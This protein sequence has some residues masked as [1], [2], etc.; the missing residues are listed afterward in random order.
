MPWHVEDIMEKRIEFVARSLQPGVNFS[1]VCR[2]FGI[3][4]TTGYLWKNRYREVGSFTE[5]HEKS[6]RPHHTP[7]RT[8]E[9]I[10][11]RVLHEQG[12]WGL[13]AKKLQPELAKLGIRLPWITIHRILQRHQKTDSSE[14][15]PA[16][17]HRF[18]REQP[19]QLWQMD[20]KGDYPIDT[21]RCY[22][23]SILDDHAR[24]AVG[25]YE[26]D[27]QTREAVQPCLIQTFE[28]YGLPD[29]FL[30]DHG[31]PWWNPN[32]GHGLTKLGVFLIQ[33][34]I[35]LYYCRIRH[36]QTQGKVERFH[37]TLNAAV[38]HR[39]LPP[40]LAGWK[41]LL[42][43]FRTMYNEKRPHE[44]LGMATPAERYTPSP[45]PYN[46]HP[47]LWEYPSGARV[48]RITPSGWM[49]FQGYSTFVC[50]ALAD[51]FVQVI[52]VEGLWLVRY[53]NRFV[54]EI[55]PRTGRSVPLILNDQSING[56]PPSAPQ[57]GERVLIQKSVETSNPL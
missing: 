44:A 31:T 42:D 33:Q 17:V 40:T 54:R 3:S 23:L 29:A 49:T 24:F 5:L 51:E 43:E 25:L 21:G 32:S 41:T 19:N 56:E 50:E 10:E 47:P 55:N 22:P 37:R 48:T 11:A 26:M 27:R 15:Q 36:P 6:R 4:R 1:A 57:R 14:K 46:P 9:E 7:T 18:E 30:L 39:G 28:T 53:R 12:N 35:R 2:E 16:A 13:G 20:F 8:A 34:G 38:R 45:R 52:E